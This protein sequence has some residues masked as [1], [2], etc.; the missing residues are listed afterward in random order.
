VE[1]VIKEEG[2]VMGKQWNQ[3]SIRV[4]WVPEGKALST[5]KTGDLVCWNKKDRESEK[6]NEKKVPGAKGQESL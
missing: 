3:V 1:R 2:L 6:L 4:T 5:A